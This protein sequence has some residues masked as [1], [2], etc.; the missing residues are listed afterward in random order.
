MAELD[1]PRWGP[2]SKATPKQLVVLCHGVGADGHDLIDLAP[3]EPPVV[4]KYVLYNG[5][6]KVRLLALLV[7]DRAVDPALVKRALAAH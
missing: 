4:H 5:P 2:A 3:S 1:G 6:A 7:G